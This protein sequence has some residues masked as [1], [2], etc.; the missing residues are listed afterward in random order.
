MKHIITIFFVLLMYWGMDAQSSWN[1]PLQL[2]PPKLAVQDTLNQLFDSEKLFSPNPI[3]QINNQ[4]TGTLISS[5]GL[6]LTTSKAFGKLPA[7]MSSQQEIP[8]QGWYARRQLYYKEVSTEVL[9]NIQTNFSSAKRE[10]HIRQNIQHLLDSLQEKGQQMWVRP[11]FEGKKYHLYAWETYSDLRL[12]SKDQE[13]GLITLRIYKEGNPL[14]TQNFLKWSTQAV[15]NDLTFIPGYP[16]ETSLLSLPL[17]ARAYFNKILPHQIQ[18]RNAVLSQWENYS[19]LNPMHKRK[20]DRLE[21]EKEKWAEL[22]YL[23]LNF[24]VQ[25]RIETFHNQFLGLLSSNHPYRQEFQEHEK[26]IKQWISVQQIKI[27]LE[28]ILNKHVQLFSLF[29]QLQQAQKQINPVPGGQEKMTE[30][31]LKNFYQSFDPELEELLLEAVYALYFKELPVQYISPIAA[32]KY[33]EAKKDAKEMVG[34][35]KNASLF[36]N[37]KTIQQLLKENSGDFELKI[38]E[39]YLFELWETIRQTYKDLVTKS[40]PPLEIKLKTIHHHYLDALEH[41]FP[42]ASGSLRY[43]I[44][45]TDIQSGFINHHLVAGMEGAPILNSRGEIVGI[46]ASGSSEQ[47]ELGKWIYEPDLFKWD[48]VIKKGDRP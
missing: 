30:L 11:V 17:T 20:K 33:T 15:N 38:Q 28:E 44:G 37:S 42:E 3:I 24:Y 14:P 18:Q 35:T 4:Y 19:N 31:I 22:A 25:A 8:L 40:I 46:F 21:S 47:L 48:Y 9:K 1:P 45:K 2:S 7:P 23:D 34:I 39:D 36:F 32:Q 29:Q 27:S 13:K 12:V 16:K 43:S 5:D 41:K 26:L 6:V 10:L